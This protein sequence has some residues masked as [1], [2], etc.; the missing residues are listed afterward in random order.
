M[1]YE[2]VVYATKDLGL[3]KPVQYI[4]CVGLDM[5]R[6]AIGVDLSLV[7]GRSH[8][9]VSADG[10]IDDIVFGIGKHLWHFLLGEDRAIRAI[11]SATPAQTCIRAAHKGMQTG[12]RLC[13]TTCRRWRV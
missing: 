7:D 13:V 12:W 6:L 10:V 1:E 3:P 4:D 2:R 8:V 5:S 9:K 11:N